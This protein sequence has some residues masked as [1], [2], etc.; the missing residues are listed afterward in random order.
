MKPNQMNLSDS[1]RAVFKNKR[2]KKKRRW[3]KKVLPN[4]KHSK[5]LKLAAFQN[6]SFPK[7]CWIVNLETKIGWTSVIQNEQHLMFSKKWCNPEFWHQ[8][9]STSWIPNEQLLKTK[10]KRWILQSDMKSEALQKFKM[11]SFW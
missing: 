7:R 8:N 2:L 10:V 5:D 9:R 11:K 1:K 3:N 4:Q 6:Q